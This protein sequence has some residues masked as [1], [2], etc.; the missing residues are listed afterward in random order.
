MRPPVR[1]RRT[2]GAKLSGSGHRFPPVVEQNFDPVKLTCMNSSL[3]EA[4]VNVNSPEDGR[5]DERTKDNQFSK[6]LITWEM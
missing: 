4:N 2:G 3:C 1:T 5:T 6:G